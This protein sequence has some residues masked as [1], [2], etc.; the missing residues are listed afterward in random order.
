M[1]EMEF[2]LHSKELQIVKADELD[3]LGLIKMLVQFI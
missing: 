3:K 1:V 2:G